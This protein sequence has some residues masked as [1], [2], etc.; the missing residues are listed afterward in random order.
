MHISDPAEVTPRDDCI[1]PALSPTDIH[2]LRLVAAN[3]RT[4]WAGTPFPALE[5]AGF[6]R[7]VRCGL[8]GVMWIA[9]DAG[10]EY[11]RAHPSL[12]EAVVAGPR[13]VA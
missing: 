10:H 8:G 4:Y 9:T 7:A 2:D 1:S 3:P 12:G 5:A 11:L 6:I 13:R